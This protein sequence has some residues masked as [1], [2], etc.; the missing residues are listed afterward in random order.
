MKLNASPAGGAKIIR[1]VKNH[2]NTYGTRGVPNGLV[3][4]QTRGQ[5]RT[6][7]RPHSRITRDEPMIVEVMFPNAERAI[8]KLRAL[9]EFLEPKTAEKKRDAASC[10]DVL[11]EAFGTFGCVNGFMGVGVRYLTSRKVRDVAEKI[12]SCDDQERDRTGL[13]QYFDG[14][15]MVDQSE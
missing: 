6:P 4:P 15:L 10:L 8:R 9:E 12:K 7:W 1:M 14:V 2:F 13:F 11:S 5:G 3:D